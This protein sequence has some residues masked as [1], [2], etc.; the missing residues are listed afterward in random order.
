MKIISN[1]R[2]FYREAKFARCILS[3]EQAHYQKMAEMY[4]TLSSLRHDFKYYI[5]KI[6]ELLQT[7]DIE[8]AKQYL[9]EIKKQ[10][11]ESGLHYYCTDHAINSLL[12]SYAKDCE[13]FNIEYNVKI[14]LPNSLSVPRYDIC[15]ILCNLL[16][17]ALKACKKLEKDREIDLAIKTD[18]QRMAIRVK[19]NFDGVNNENANLKSVRAVAERYGGHIS[20]EQT[21]SVFTIYVMV[22]V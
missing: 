3:A 5:K 7:G 9:T 19:N 20:M 4:E 15:I 1:I 22:N 17:N 10:I 6:D 12:T 18:G 11:P 8:K 21:G 14:V 2:R 13:E 16:E